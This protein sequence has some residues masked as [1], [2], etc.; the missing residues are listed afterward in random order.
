MRALADLGMWIYRLM[1]PTCKSTTSQDLK[2]SLQPSF[3][4]V[5]SP[6]L[7]YIYDAVCACLC[8]S[9]C[10]SVWLCVCVVVCVCRS[11]SSSGEP[12]VRLTF[13]FSCVSRC[14]CWGGGG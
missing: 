14:L 13:L 11:L 5:Q 1:S 2:V 4:K 7:C 9:V 8:V 12:V 10:V 3:H 6:S